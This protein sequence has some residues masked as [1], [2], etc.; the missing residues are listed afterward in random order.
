MLL[1]SERA[2]ERAE[3]NLDGRRG[4][5]R[6]EC[7]RGKSEQEGEG[8][9]DFGGCTDAAGPGNTNQRYGQADGKV[10]PWHGPG[11]LSRRPAISN[12]LSP[13]QQES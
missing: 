11:V 8:G 9:G 4:R 10:G 7:K 6:A 13:L 5:K 3:Y 12:S 2:S 1:A